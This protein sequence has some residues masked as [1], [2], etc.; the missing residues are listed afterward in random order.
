MTNTGV[1]PEGR[2]W[3]IGSARPESE[4]YP[5]AD[6]YIWGAFAGLA[7][8]LGGY[9]DLEAIDPYTGRRFWLA[10]AL[11][12]DAHAAELH[13]AT[14]GAEAT[15][16]YGGTHECADCHGSTLTAMR[17]L[18]DAME[19]AGFPD[20]RPI[21]QGV[22][23]RVAL[24]TGERNLIVSGLDRLLAQEVDPLT[25]PQRVHDEARALRDKVTFS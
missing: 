23:R 12:C 21:A 17:R 24:D 13:A 6:K 15:A 9:N 19:Q 1:T 7:I 3:S 25:H 14:P 4:C 10:S 8:E 5:H 20:E 2:E 11:H 16:V 18:F 22:G